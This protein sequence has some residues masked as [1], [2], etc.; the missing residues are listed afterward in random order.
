MVFAISFFVNIYKVR[1]CLLRQHCFLH[2]TIRQHLA[3]SYR[4]M[5]FVA[6]FLCQFCIC[7]L[8][9]AYTFSPF[10]VKYVQNKKGYA[11]NKIMDKQKAPL[12]GALFYFSFLKNTAF[13]KRL[14]IPL[15]TNNTPKQPIRFVTNGLP[16]SSCQVRLMPASVTK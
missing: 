3:L 14:V 5:G 13:I 4:G 9:L 15:Q 8:S 1:T 7:L 10:F 11:K 12:T 2:P 6:G 16:T